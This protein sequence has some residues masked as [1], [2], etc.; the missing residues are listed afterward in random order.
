MEHQY[1]ELKNI[2]LDMNNKAI[3][4]MSDPTAMLLCTLTHMDVHRI[5]CNI[6]VCTPF[7]MSIA[8]HLETRALSI[9]PPLIQLFMRIHHTSHHAPCSIVS[10]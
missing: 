2:L 5:P 6:Y 7:P 1:G 8:Y 10:M 3:A 9:F 4:R